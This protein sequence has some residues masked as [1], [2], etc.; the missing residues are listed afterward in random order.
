MPTVLVVDDSAVD[1][2][3]IGGLLEK[4]D[5]LQVD[6]AENGRSALAKIRVAAPNLIVTDLQM[7][8]M[9]GLDLVRAVSIHHSDTPVILMTAHGSEDLAVAALEQGA[10]SYV[11]KSRV[12]EKLLDTVHQVLSL[13]HAAGSYDRL[14]ECMDQTEFVFTLGNDPSVFDPLVELV[15]QIVL[16]M[17][18]TTPSERFSV[19]S[20]LQEALLNAYYRGNLEISREQMQEARERM[21]LGEDVHLVEDRCTQTPY[22]DRKIHVKVNIIRDEARFTVRDDGSGFDVSKMPQIVDADAIEGEGGRG[23][24]L[25]K[26]CMDEVLHNSQGNEITMIKRRSRNADA[27]ASS[28]YEFEV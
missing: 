3:L 5:R 12:A 16:G 10:A 6:Y 13:S 27:A 21:L 24:V 15:Q 18:V 20:A 11:P 14:L 8:E 2:R 17:G 9:D 22:C 23:L 4:D 19:G 26:A 7:P 25:I 1:R 28:D